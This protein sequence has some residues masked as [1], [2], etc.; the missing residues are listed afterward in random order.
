MTV[1]I[2]KHWQ[3]ACRDGVSSLWDTRNSTG[4]SSGQ[5]TLGTMAELDDL[6]QS[7]STSTTPRSSFA[8]CKQ[9]QELVLQRTSISNYPEVKADFR[10]QCVNVNKSKG[11]AQNYVWLA[12]KN[13]AIP[14]PQHI[15]VW[16]SPFKLS[17]CSFNRESF[18]SQKRSF[19]VYTEGGSSDHGARSISGVDTEQCKQISNGA[20]TPSRSKHIESSEVQI[21]WL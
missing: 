16:D 20:W 5:P 15:L 1:W 12:A 14:I 18:T 21:S 11:N 13:R 3:V 2:V 8:A 17:L 19:C 6:Q 4:V 7:L 9:K 10:N